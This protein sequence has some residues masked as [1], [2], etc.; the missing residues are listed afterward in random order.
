M[1]CWKVNLLLLRSG[2]SNRYLLMIGVL[3]LTITLFS[4]QA[5]A[6]E[7]YKFPSWVKSN[8]KFWSEGSIRDSDFVKGI[9]YLVEQGIVRIPSTPG[10]NLQNS[11]QIPQWIKSNAGFWSD[12]QINDSEFVKGMQYLVQSGV[13]QVSI[14]STGNT[15][16]FGIEEIYPTVAGGKEWFSKWD[17]RISRT[18][19]YSTDPPTA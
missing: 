4:S 6:Q 10:G 11:N 3:T 1:T 7:Y 9:Q 12:G 13:I 14:A 2:S 15:D 16:K 5:S 8:A 19:G 17:N 18:F